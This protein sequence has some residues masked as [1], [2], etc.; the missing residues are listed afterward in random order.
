MNFFVFRF[1]RF[2]I[3]EYSAVE[4]TFDVF[5]RCFLRSWRNSPALSRRG[6]ARWLEEKAK[7]PHSSRTKPNARQIRRDMPVS[8]LSVSRKLSIAINRDHL[9]IRQEVDLL[10]AFQEKQSSWCKRWPWGRVELFNASSRRRPKGSRQAVA[11]GKSN[12]E[13]NSLLWPHNRYSDMTLQLDVVS[14]SPLDR[15]RLFISRSLTHSLRVYELRYRTKKSLRLRRCQWEISSF[16]CVVTGPRRPVAI[17]NNRRHHNKLNDLLSRKTER[18]ER[19]RTK[20]LS[21][22]LTIPNRCGFQSDLRGSR[23]CD[24]WLCVRRSRHSVFL[25]F[26]WFSY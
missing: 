24:C 25:T 2:G 16:A 20:R 15:S 22:D 11:N 7:R 1:R 17:I 9:T 10:G 6:V 19:V 26:S 18:R 14:S 5:V 4:T 13:E 21:R 3:Y 23:P 12:A 8:V